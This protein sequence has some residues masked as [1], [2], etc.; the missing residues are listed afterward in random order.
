MLLVKAHVSNYRSA[1]DS[2]E[3]TVEPAACSPG[4]TGC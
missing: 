3:F 2:E 1:E 4:S